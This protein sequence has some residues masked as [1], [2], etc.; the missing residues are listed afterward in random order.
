MKKIILS[1][2][3]VVIVVVAAWW[4]MS[5]E[6]NAPTDTTPTVSASTSVS[7]SVSVKPTVTPKPTATA[8]ANLTITSPKNGATVTS[9]VT[10]TGRA[11]IFENQFSVAIT[12][13]DGHVIVEKEGV[14][15]D[16]KDSGQFGNYSVSLTIPDTA[17]TDIRIVAYAYSA[18]GDGSYEGYAEVQVKRKGLVVQFPQTSP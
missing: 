17:P 13:L 7:P 10:V 2:I 15:S 8:Q 14:M 6:V 16:A 3:A 4:F 12:D 11:R 9:P 18:K 1:I 5:H